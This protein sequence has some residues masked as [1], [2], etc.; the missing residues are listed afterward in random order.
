LFWYTTTGARRLRSGAWWITC[1][2]GSASQSL[3][4]LDANDVFVRDDPGKAI[5]LMEDH[6]CDLLFSSERESFMYDCMPEVRS[7]LEE[8]TLREG[9]APRFLNT[10]VFVCQPGILPEVF[11]EAMRYIRETEMTQGERVRYIR[12]GSLRSRLP[13]FPAGV[14]SDQAILRYV[15]PRFHPRVRVDHADAL[16]WRKLPEGGAL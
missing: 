14:G 12:D 4:Y 10:G 13:D 8:L 6:G 7:W 3:L 9:L 2:A 11:G 16:A 15:Q 5:R 1:A